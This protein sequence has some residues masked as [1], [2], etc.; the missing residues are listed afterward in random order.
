M[1]NKTHP[2][3]FWFYSSTET[4]LGT[5]QPLVAFVLEEAPGAEGGDAFNK[6]NEMSPRQH[7]K[8]SNDPLSVLCH[9]P[10]QEY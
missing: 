7:A 6:G 1:F 10:R 9:N 8:S 5:F 2:F 3:L 4:S